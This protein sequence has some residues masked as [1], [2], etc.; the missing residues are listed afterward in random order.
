MRSNACVQADPACQT[1]DDLNPVG[2]LDSECFFPVGHFYIRIKPTAW[3]RNFPATSGA[4]G[5]QRPSLGE[6][7]KSP[8]LTGNY[9]MYF[10]QVTKVVASDPDGGDHVY[11][12][13]DKITI[14]FSVKMSQLREREREREMVRNNM[15]EI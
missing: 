15:R 13:G 1:L 11:S 3:L 2:Y 7:A 5:H 6:Y 10:P 4:V 9:G 14:H 8:T 12:T